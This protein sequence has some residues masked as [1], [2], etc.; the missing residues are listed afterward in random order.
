MNQHINRL[1]VDYTYSSSVNTLTKIKI[2]VTLVQEHIGVCVGGG[3]GG[4]V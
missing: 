3:G 1:L 4:G 2:L